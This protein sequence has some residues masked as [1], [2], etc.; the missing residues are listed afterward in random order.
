MIKI[1]RILLESLMPTEDEVEMIGSPHKSAS[2]RI[3][4]KMNKFK[5]VQCQMA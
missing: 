2:E 1:C 3:I 4:E 5:E